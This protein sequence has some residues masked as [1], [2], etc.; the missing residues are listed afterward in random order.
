MEKKRVAVLMGG[1]GAGFHPSLKSGEVVLQSLRGSVYE[2]FAVFIDRNGRWDTPP[3]ELK[4]SAD[5]AFVAL[6]GPYGEDG[7]VQSILEFHRIPHTSSRALSSALAMNKFLTLQTI[8]DHDIRIPNTLFIP[9]AEWHTEQKIVLKTAKE[10]IGFPAVVKPNRAGLAL[11]VF[12]VTNEKELSEKLAEVFHFTNEALVQ[13]YIQGREFLCGVLDHGWSESAFPLV[14][15]EIFS[16]KGPLADFDARQKDAGLLQILPP[17]NL[18]SA[19]M[20][21]LQNTA[22]H[23]HRRVGAGGVSETDIIMDATGK[24][25]VLEVNTIPQFHDRSS[26]LYAAAESNM[27]PEKLFDFMIRGALHADYEHKKQRS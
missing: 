5:C 18:P 17:K 14:P 7:T 8:A 25:F 10:R 19:R 12:L 16:R 21:A 20:K 3:D 26:F 1:P 2:P 23:V 6:H 22:L 11:H 13:E 9:K 15:V 4:H 27:P 24:I